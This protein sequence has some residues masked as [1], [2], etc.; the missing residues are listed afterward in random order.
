MIF[1]GLKILVSPAKRWSVLLSK[2]HRRLSWLI[3]AAITAAVFPSI[4]VVAGHLGAAFLGCELQQVA[5]QRAAVGLVA[6][7]TG[8]MVMAPACTLIVSSA[9]KNARVSHN[10]GIA[11]SSAM[12]FLWPIWFCGFIMIIPP[13]FN[14]GPEPGEIAWFVLGCLAVFRIIK[15]AAV[16]ELKIRRR[17]KKQFIVQMSVSLILLFAIV[18]FVPAFT[19]RYFMGVSGKTAIEEVSPIVW[20]V[21]PASDW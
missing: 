19:V 13:L 2:E 16:N 8:V 4:A 1:N 12:G 6:T 9:L 15:K 10:M 17:W 20:P 5:I 21:P 7:F 18:P 11:A 3:T 14:M